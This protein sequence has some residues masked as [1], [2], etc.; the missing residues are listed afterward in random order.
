MQANE[1]AGRIAPVAELI[2]T[3]EIGE[4]AQRKLDAATWALLAPAD[5]AAFDRITFRPRMMVNTTG[6]DISLELFGQKH[7]AP[8]IVGPVSK[9]KRFHPEGELEMAKGAAAAKAAIVLPSDSSIPLEQVVPL[10]KAGAWF[11]VNLD[12]DM[13]KAIAAAKQAVA[14][15]C[16]VVCATGTNWKSLASLTKAVSVPV[17]AKGI[18]TPAQAEA[19]IAAGA[20]GLIVSNWVSGA[21]AGKNEAIEVLPMVAE[22]VEDRVPVLADGGFR[23][24]S[25]LLKGLALGAKAILVARAPACGLAAYGAAGVQRALEILQTD[26]ARDMAMCGKANLSLLSRDAVKVHRF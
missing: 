8:L 21:A 9:Q 19:A 13:T 5:R 22:A 6:L 14:A 18:L 23:R 17:V 3:Y 16:K 26:L 24:G 1:P 4:M 20:Q 10:A 12:A 25:D 2:N 11:Q 15:G 7:F